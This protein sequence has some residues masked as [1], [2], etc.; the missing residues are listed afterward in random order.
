LKVSVTQAPEKGKA[1]RAIAEF[2]AKMLGLKKSQIRLLNGEKCSEKEF[3][4]AAIAM[5]ELRDRIIKCLL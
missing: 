5:D 4:I 3:L 1:N 2:L